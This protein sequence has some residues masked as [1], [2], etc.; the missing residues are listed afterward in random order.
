[1]GLSQLEE[2]TPFEQQQTFANADGTALKDVA[3]LTT[4]N[5]RIDAIFVTST[6]TA[7]RVIDLYWNNGGAD[8]LLGSANVPAGAGTGGAATV[9]LV[10]TILGTSPG[11]FVLPATHKLR[12]SMESAV[13]AAKTVDVTA[14]GGTL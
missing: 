10:A 11:Q 14:L 13:T 2:K 3:S 12:A 6:D 8:S 5:Y 7:A 1:M 4:S 9:D